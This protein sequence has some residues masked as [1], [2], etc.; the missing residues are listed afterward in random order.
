MTSLKAISIGTFDA[1]HL[2]HQAIIAAAREAV[3]KQGTVAFHSFDP[4][5]LSVIKPNLPFHRL[6]SIDNR[7][8]LLKSYGVDEVIVLAPSQS[9]L[10]MSPEA[11][12]LDLVKQHQPDVIIEGENFRFGKDR[13]G[14]IKT[15]QS[16]GEEHRFK[17][18]SV[19]HVE[20]SMKDHS[21]VQVSSS[22]VRSLLQ[23]G[24]VE[25]AATLLGR[26]YLI[27]GSVVQG[28][29]R[30]R[31]IGF[32]TA[33]MSGIQTMLPMDGVYA[34][35]TTIEGENYPVALSIG[36]KPTFAEDLVSCEAHVIGFDGKVDH[37]EWELTV[38]ITAWIR[39]QIKFATIEALIEAIH[40]DIERTLELESVV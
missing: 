9:L 8:S 17:V 38:T 20:R 13:S 2:G 5:P 11:F 26:P 1:V 36:T 3:G 14:T 16:L 4:P 25:D 10:E 22:M 34:G 6:T 27:S 30:G 37:Y 28:D 15:L 23:L 31:K 19:A 29:Q 39:N 18:I 12:V 32:P 7:I 24:R 35:N 40:K 21:V 33:N